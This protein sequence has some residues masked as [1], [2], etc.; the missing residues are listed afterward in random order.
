MKKV[1]NKVMTAEPETYYMNSARSLD[2]KTNPSIPENSQN[3]N[4]NASISTNHPKT[5]TETQQNNNYVPYSSYS[6]NS[7]RVYS[8][9]PISVTTANPTTWNSNTTQGNIRTYGYQSPP[10]VIRKEEVTTPE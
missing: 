9:T 2:F 4:S 3:I 5:H 10:K 7:P 6:N 1:V 8:A